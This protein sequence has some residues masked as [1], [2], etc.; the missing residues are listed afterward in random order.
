MKCANSGGGVKCANSGRER[1]VKCANSGRSP[2]EC[3]WVSKRKW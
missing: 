1:T 2:L 3:G